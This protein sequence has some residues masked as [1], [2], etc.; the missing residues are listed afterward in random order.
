MSFNIIYSAHAVFT[1]SCSAGTGPSVT[2]DASATSPISQRDADRKAAAFARDRA[3]QQLECLFPLPPDEVRFFSDEATASS[4]CPAGS[5]DPLEVP[6]DPG[7][8]VEVTLP[9]GSVYST[10]SV[11]AANTAAQA[12]ADFELDFRIARTCRGFFENTEQTATVSCPPFTVGADSSDTVAA[13]TFQSFVNQGA[14]DAQAFALALANATAGL[15]C[16]QAF[17]NEAQSFTA[18]CPVEGPFGPDVTVT[19]PAGSYFDATVGAAN[20]TALAAATA[21]ATA[22]LVCGSTFTNTEQTATIDCDAVYFEPTF[23]DTSSATVAAGSFFSDVSQAAVDAIALSAAEAEALLNL[24]CTCPGG[25]NPI[26][27]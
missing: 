6:F 22:A 17:P 5:A 23:G 20:A 15:S 3:L 21:Q 16:A 12:W 8:V 26:N 13:G 25:C 10:V 7:K 24:N 9:A 2:A 1:V 18:S 4:T 19:V 27:P 14:V 11:A